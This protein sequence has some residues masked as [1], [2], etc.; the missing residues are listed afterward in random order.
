M[1]M[2]AAILVKQNDPLIVAEVEIPDLAAGQ[3]LVKV[4]R[5]GICGK[6]V[7]EI[8]GKRGEDLFLPHLLGHEG[9]GVVVEAG[10][11]VRKVKSGDHVVL[12]WMK[13][14]G[15]DAAPPRYDWDGVQVSAGWVTTFNEYAIV[16]ENRVTSID[17]EVGFD[18]AALLGCAVTT[19]LG[20]V[21]NDADLKPGQ[22]VAIFGA[23]GIGLNAVQGAALV[24]AYPIVAVDI[25]DHKLESAIA[26]GATHTVNSKSQDPEAF[27]NELTG[28][29]GVSVSVDTTGNSKVFEMAYRVTSNTGTAVLAGVL[30]HEQPIT[31]DPYKLHFGRRI[32]ASHGGNTR[33]DDDIPRY[34]QLYKLGK[35]KLDEQI[36][37]SY[38]LSEINEAMDSVRSGR[39]LRC[40][41]SIGE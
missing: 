14:S 34:I 36:T 20:I 33:P 19:G 31:I 4:E 22:S 1:E 18:V 15:M 26:F 16:S 21:F 38:P 24:N 2:N 25:E 5:S 23:G 12:H 7:D 32:V 40:M 8:T 29:N 13:G 28:G 35:L 9:A 17:P 37:H 41:V 6:Q 11:G 3:V 39:A 10:P 27:L 30:H